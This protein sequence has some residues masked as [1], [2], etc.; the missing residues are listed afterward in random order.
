MRKWFVFWA[1][2]IA[3]VGCDEEEVTYTGSL[4]VYWNPPTVNGSP[5]NQ[6]RVAIFDMSSLANYRFSE[7]EAIEVKTLNSRVDFMDLNPGNYVVALLELPD[8][9]KVGQVKIGKQTTIILME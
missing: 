3:A 5:L 6:F 4:T 9:R 1:F 2:L 8:F 7:T